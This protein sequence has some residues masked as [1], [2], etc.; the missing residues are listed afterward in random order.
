MPYSNKIIGTIVYSYSGCQKRIAV[1]KSCPQSMI[2]TITYSF[3]V[4]QINSY[5]HH[6]TWTHSKC[7]KIRCVTSVT[8]DK[9]RC[10]TSVTR[11]KIRCVTSVTRDKMA[12][13][14]MCDLHEGFSLLDPFCGGGTVPIEASCVSKRLSTCFLQHKLHYFRR[15]GTGPIE[16]HVY[17]KCDFFVFTECVICMSCGEDMILVE[18]SYV[19]EILCM[20]CFQNILHVCLVEETSYL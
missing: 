16:N 9:M 17:V 11:D 3:S 6:I 12:C 8:R 14:Q 18:V 20:C 10:V 4:W 1:T 7:E 2:G 13:M 19:S 15:S 5:R